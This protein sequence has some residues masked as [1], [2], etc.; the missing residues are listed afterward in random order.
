M[1][2]L[3]QNME[4]LQE[5]IYVEYI[6]MCVCIYIERARKREWSSKYIVSAQILVKTIGVIS[7][8]LTIS[9]KLQENYRITFA[10]YAF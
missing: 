4:R 10:S 2:I 3:F 7:L 9:M 8:A 1:D 6:H 5:D